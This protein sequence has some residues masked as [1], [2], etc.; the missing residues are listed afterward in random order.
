MFLGCLGSV[1]LWGKREQRASAEAL[2]TIDHQHWLVAQ[3]QGRPRLE[4]PPLPRWAIAA[5]M[6]LTGRRDEWMVRLPSAASALASVA[7]VYALGRRMGGRSLGLA[8]ALVLCSF[9]SFVSEMRQASNDGPLTFF[10]TLALFAAWCSLHDQGARHSPALLDGA[11][12]SRAPQSGPAGPWGW[13]LVF[14]AALGLG[15]LTK[16]PII[17]LLVAVTLIPYLAFSSRLAWGLHRL[18]NGPGLLVL[19]AMALSWPVAVMV[20]DP[21]ALR[22]WWLEIAEKTGVSQM[23]RHRRHSL[24]LEQWPAMVLPWSLIALVAVILPFFRESDDHAD[25]DARPRSESWGQLSCGAW[26]LWFAWWWAVGNLLLFSLWSIAKSNYYLPCMPS[27]ALLTGA[28]WIRLGRV[29]RGRSGASRAARAILQAQWVALFVVAVVAP[30]VTR[31]WLP[32]TVWLWSVAIAVAL[33]VAVVVSVHF[34]RHGADALSLAPITAACVLGILI[35]YGI[36]A[37]VDNPR[38][39]HR[40]LAATIRR[41]VPKDVR[42]LLFFNEIDEGLWFYLRGPNLAPLPGSH[43]RY[44]TAFDLVESYHSLRLPRETLD[45]LDAKRQ[46]HDRQALIQW[47]DQIDPGKKPYLLIRTNLYDRFATEL[48]GRVTPLFRETGLKRN[49]LVLLRAAGPRPLTATT[50]SPTRR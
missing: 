3:I 42:T 4:K 49:E 5:L 24:L 15:F 22:I 12:D 21:N 20:E 34:W 23:L 35:A 11:T 43:P 10:T 26:P 9:G 45:E 36:I 29:A 40:D 1:D 17:L 27:V 25:R 28:A 30:L 50:T 44:N 2:D 8:S 41:L 31:L 6:V 33:V 37:P 16:G 7:L 18:A 48:A 14:Y 19:S 13:N 32:R 39:S 38:R 47:L 46:A